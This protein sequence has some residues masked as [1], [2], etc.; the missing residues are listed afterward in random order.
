MWIL[1][2]LLV[3]LGVACCVGKFLGF[4]S[5]NDRTEEYYKSEGIPYKNS[6]GKIV[7]SVWYCK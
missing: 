2:A 1:A 5:K 7:N 6:E 3:S 4:C